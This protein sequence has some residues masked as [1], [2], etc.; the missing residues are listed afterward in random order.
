MNTEQYLDC[1]RGQWL[2]FPNGPSRDTFFPF[3]DWCAPTKNWRLMYTHEPR[4]G[5]DP[6]FADNVLGGEVATW[7]ETID[8]ASLDAIVWPRA[9]VAGEI[10]WS[11]ITDNEG[12]NRS[13]YDIRPRLSEQRERMLARGVRGGPITQLW[14]DQND[15]ADCGHVE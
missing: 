11:G 9:G 6:E 13:Q 10:W 5:V 3:N 14:C 4:D 8:N 15:V 7:T 1:G 12:Q 2:D